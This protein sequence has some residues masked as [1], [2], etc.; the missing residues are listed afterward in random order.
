MGAGPRGWQTGPVSLRPCPPEDGAVPTRG[1][2]GSRPAAGQAF[3]AQG[4][5]SRTWTSWCHFSDV[6]SG[7][8]PQTGC[9]KPKTRE[10]LVGRSEVPSPTCVSALSP[11]GPFR[12][13]TA[14]P[15][16]AP[17]RPVGEPAKLQG[18]RARGKERAEP[19]LCSLTPKPPVHREAFSLCKQFRSFTSSRGVSLGPGAGP[20]PVPHDPKTCHR[21]GHRVL[22]T[23]HS[24]LCTARR[25]AVRLGHPHPPA[26][27]GRGAR[28]VLGTGGSTCRAQRGGNSLPPPPKN[29]P[30]CHRR[31]HA[32][33]PET[34]PIQQRGPEPT[35]VLREATS[36]RRK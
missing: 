34:G 13:R 7:H 19:H 5:A 6:G 16:S 22:W 29:K 18:R 21:A 15:T 14:G 24:D 28:S 32:S 27:W 30:G 1:A 33:F 4:G 26:G 36:T 23:L 20:L 31:N 2:G 35:S 11:P 3:S 17:P 9:L 10:L 12:S 25:P 8:Y